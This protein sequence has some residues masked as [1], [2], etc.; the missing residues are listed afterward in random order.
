MPSTLASFGKGHRFAPV[1]FELSQDWVRDYVV[2]VE[3]DAIAAMSGFVPPMSL[4]ALSIR[5]LLDEASLPPGSI[6]VGQELSFRRAV[7]VGETLTVQAEITSRGERQ[8]WILM[9]V[10]M[11]VDDAA[12]SSVMEGRATITFPLEASDG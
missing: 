6:H 12:E 3:D 5:A 8:G 7:A 9:G 2:A 11:T 10:A 1:H 4:A